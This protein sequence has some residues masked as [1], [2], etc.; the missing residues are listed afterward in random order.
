MYVAVKLVIGDLYVVLYVEKFSHW[1][2]RAIGLR[3]NR[4]AQLCYG[5]FIAN[6]LRRDIL[7][8][9]LNG[10]HPEWFS[11]AM[12]P[13]FLWVYIRVLP[14]NEKIKD[15]LTG[16]GF[17]NHRKLMI[18]FI[19]VRLFFMFWVL[20]YL[21]LGIVAMKPGLMV[22]FGMSML[23]LC[24]YLQ[25]CDDLPPGQSRVRGWLNDIAAFGKTPAE[26]KSNV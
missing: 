2:Q 14:D 12:L 6:I 18:P 24:E 26:V 23:T 22:D 3:S 5:A 11:L 1:L 9:V 19:A 7:T 21:T 25:A 10:K 4:T 20:L 13:L 8:P 15:Q 17:M 16:N